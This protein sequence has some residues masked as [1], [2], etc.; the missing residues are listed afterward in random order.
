MYGKG[1]KYL[2]KDDSEHRI[3]HEDSE[4]SEDEIDIHEIVRNGTLAEVKESIARDRPRLI[5]LKD[6]LGRTVLHYAAE[7]DRVKI[8]LHL[9]AKNADINAR[10]HQEKTPLHLAAAKGHTEI[11]I[12]N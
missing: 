2:R 1:N 10:D 9:I 4:D 7:L 12:I 5:A 8:A 3:D 11:Y 6:E